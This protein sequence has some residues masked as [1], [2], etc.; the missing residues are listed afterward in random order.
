MTV[1]NERE[2]DKRRILSTS[3]TDLSSPLD[4]KADRQATNEVDSI[5]ES[6]LGYSDPHGIPHGL[7]RSSS[8]SSESPTDDYAQSHRD[9][10][11]SQST[12]QSLLSASDSGPSHTAYLTSV[13]HQTPAFEDFKGDRTPPKQSAYSSLPSSPKHERDFDFGRTAVGLGLPPFGDK[14]GRLEPRAES[15]SDSEDLEQY[16]EAANVRSGNE[17]PAS[18]SNI[19]QRVPPQSSLDTTTA[20]DAHIHEPLSSPTQ[21]REIPSLFELI[22]D[23]A[24]AEEWDG[25]I[26]DGRW[27][28]IGNFLAV[29]FAVEQ[30]TLFG[31]L[32]CLDGFLYNFTV[33][34][35]RA[36]VATSQI[37][38]R[39]IRLEPWWPVPASH[40]HSMIRALLLFIPALVLSLASD[41]SKMYHSVRGQDTIKLYVIFNALEIAD[42]LCGAFG[43]DVL[44]TLFARDTLAPVSRK[45]G[46]GRKRQQ[47][48]PFFFFML[49]LGY[50][51]LHTLVFFYMLIS[52][53]VAINSYDYTLLSLLISNQFV[54]IKGS[55]FKKFDKENLLQIMCA[56]IVERF[57]LSLMLS[58]IAIRNMIE[59]AGSDLAYLPKSF[60]AGKSLL[61]AIMSP[62]VFVIVSEMLVDWL[63]HAFITKFNHVRASVYGRFTDVLAKDV[64]AV[65]TMIVN[66]SQTTRRSRPL[67]MDQ[68]PLV[69][70]RLGFASIPL[71]CLV[72]RVGAQAIKMLVNPTHNVEDVSQSL[73]ASWTWWMVKW[74]A[75]SVVIVGAWVCLVVF[76]VLLGLSLLKYSLRRQDGMDTREAEDV[77]NDAGRSQVG[78]GRE[79]TA[80]LR[81]V[82][83]HLS[84]SEDDLPEYPMP[85]SNV[86][87][88]IDSRD[89]PTLNLEGTRGPVAD[90]AKRKQWKLEEVER[91]TMVK[92]IW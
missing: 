55:V 60:S 70:R 21:P 11:R 54:E 57:Q 9:P 38:R 31:A 22:Y 56:D 82:S 12:H 40:L 80:Y 67:L 16:W 79:E 4:I 88:P 8:S 36:V 28:R 59:M 5:E 29:P 86:Q 1:N 25:W 62:V 37:I 3:M 48:R 27:E 52:L 14:L 75:G 83:Q 64:L 15:T 81:Q 41:T 19:R 2:P 20:N 63:K 44:D 18:L 23:E 53:N 30:L 58:V 78:V 77:V 34:P 32:L 49:S 50:V 6:L 90:K 35:I 85:S 66:R 45:V 47:A 61:D 72:L 26:V 74:S 92:R 51:F 10:W 46:V 33:L 73:L 7:S 76:K 43:Q 89:H 17:T 24:G 69:A 42:K 84:K 71:S 91:W 87:F 65:N 68:S 13:S 39:R